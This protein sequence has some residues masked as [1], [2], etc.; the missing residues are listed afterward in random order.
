MQTEK[1]REDK[2]RPLAL[3]MMQP[4]FLFLAPSLF[5]LAAIVG[6]GANP[7]FSSGPRRVTLLE[8]YTS[9]GCS[10]CPPAEKSFAELLDD[11][12]LWKQIVPISFHV[13]YFD[14]ASWHDRFG[15]KAFTDRQ[16]QYART[17]PDDTVYTPCLIENG[18]EYRRRDNGRSEANPAGVLFAE[19]LDNNHVQVRFAPSAGQSAGRFDA[20]IAVVGSGLSSNVRGGENAGRN[21]AHEFVALTLQ[22]AELQPD[23]AGLT[24]DIVL[25]KADAPAATRHGLAVWV[26]RH[27]Q[28]TPVQ[29][30]G[31]WLD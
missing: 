17:W 26:S 5:C 12:R 2:S 14:T 27:G 9:E 18:V 1:I 10:S 3:T 11:S 23:A 24:I 20:Y 30:T 28:L 15:G 31:G 19:R 16:Y 6:L 7:T 22:K 29:A 8:L 25:G 13:T 4:R 21:L